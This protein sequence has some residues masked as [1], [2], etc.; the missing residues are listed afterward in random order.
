MPDLHL[1]R[2]H[3]LGL[4]RAR[5]IARQWVTEASEQLGMDCEYTTGDTQDRI[6]FSRTGV[7]GELRV[8]ACRF[9]LEA[10]LGFL[11]GTFK[12]RI[13]AEISRNLDRLLA[14]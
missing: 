1:T 11:L 3:D 5:E 13:E 9:E 6:A 7:S 4:D 10:R 12:D 8:D 14:G 2:E